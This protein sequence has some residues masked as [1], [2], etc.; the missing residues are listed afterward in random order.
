MPLV[1]LI[2]P[3]KQVGHQP[4][5]SLSIYIDNIVSPVF[6]FRIGFAL[7]HRCFGHICRLSVK[8]P[9]RYVYSNENTMLISSLLRKNTWCKV[10]CSLCG[11]VNEV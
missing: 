1:M 3:S 8:M 9:R 7:V 4:C 6:Y 5:P 10:Q 2:T 11:E